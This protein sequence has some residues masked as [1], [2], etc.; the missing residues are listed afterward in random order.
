MM[1]HLMMMAR[2]I[3]AYHLN[4]VHI[5]ARRFPRIFQWATG[6][7]TENI[8]PFNPLTDEDNGKRKPTAVC[9]H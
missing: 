9:S 1:C 3:T 7:R 5:S 4:S 6:I 8:P 2:D